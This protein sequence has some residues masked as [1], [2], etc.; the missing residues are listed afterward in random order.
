MSDSSRNY[1]IESKINEDITEK[2]LQTRF[3]LPPAPP[4]KCENA[5]ND[6]QKS[7]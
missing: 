2:N 6:K 3:Q 5:E 4:K 1:N 7:Q